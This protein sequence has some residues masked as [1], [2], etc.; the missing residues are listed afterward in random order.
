MAAEGEAEASGVAEGA[1]VAERSGEVACAGTGAGVGA[2][3]G[4]EAVTFGTAS[5]DPG[6]N[7]AERCSEP[8][9]AAGEPSSCGFAV[10]V[11]GAAGGSGA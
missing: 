1:V 4:V 8:V 7:A 5:A 3:A 11:F 10:A 6:I 9:A 2:G